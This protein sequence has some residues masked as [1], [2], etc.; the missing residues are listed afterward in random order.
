MTD[1]ILVFGFYL[2]SDLFLVRFYQRI[3]MQNVLAAS[4]LSAIITGMVLFGTIIAITNIQ[5]VL[6]AVI[7]AGLGT[8]WGMRK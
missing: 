6:A 8:A 5:L 2:L 4:C 7:G 3:N 1:A